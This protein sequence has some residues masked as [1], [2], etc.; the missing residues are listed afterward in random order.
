MT[1]AQCWTYCLNIWWWFLSF[2]FVPTVDGRAERPHPVRTTNS[3]TYVNSSVS[4][5]MLLRFVSD[6]GYTQK[7]SLPSAV[8]PTELK[9]TDTVT[10]L[11][12]IQLHH[13][14]LSSTHKYVCNGVRILQ[15]CCLICRTKN[16]EARTY[17][18][19]TTNCGD[20]QYSHF[21]D[22]TGLLDYTSVINKVK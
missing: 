18:R 16:T 1:A 15:F 4:V 14:N 19:Q 12:T 7:Q 17:K 11:A 13:I 20:V 5:C 6:A 8:A 2:R 21:E 3:V 9:W 10:S 22:I